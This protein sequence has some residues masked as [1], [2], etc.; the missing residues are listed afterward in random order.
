MPCGGWGAACGKRGL[1]A[2][3][4]MDLREQQG[5]RSVMLPA[6]GRRHVADVI[7]S[8]FHSGFIK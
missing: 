8:I 3:V 4:G 6:A 7:Y 1:G 5:S 2:D